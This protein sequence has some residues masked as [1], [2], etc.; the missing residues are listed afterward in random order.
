MHHILLCGLSFAALAQ[1]HPQSQSYGIQGLNGSAVTNGTYVLPMFD[2]NP[3]ARATEIQKNRA[4]YLYGPSL[5]G[6]S[7][8]FL[9]GPLGDQLVQAEVALWNK[10]AA[11]VRAAVQ[12][13]ATPVLQSV[14]AVSRQQAQKYCYTDTVT[15]SGRR[16]QRPI[17]L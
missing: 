1:A 8:F 14:G 7:S 16:N 5:I 17:E 6:N 13:E 10:D 9:T 11:P 2:P 4:G 3:A 15:L 12:A